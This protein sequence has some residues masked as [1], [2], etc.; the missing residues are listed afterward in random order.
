MLGKS[1]RVF[2]FEPTP[3]TH[4]LLCRTLRLNGLD[5]RVTSRCAAAGRENVI[6]PLYVSTISPVTIRFTPYPVLRNDG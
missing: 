2:A 1:G 3:S 5:D 6:K 4:E